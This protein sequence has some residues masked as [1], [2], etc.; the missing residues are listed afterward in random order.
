MSGGVAYVLDEDGN[1][2]KRCNMSMVQLEPV[3]EELATLDSTV[4][5]RKAMV[6]C[7]SIISIRLMKQVLTEQ[8]ENH[9]RYTDSPARQTKF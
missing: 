5:C 7:I 9:L 1:F 2:E 4:I 6:A 8:V 3:P